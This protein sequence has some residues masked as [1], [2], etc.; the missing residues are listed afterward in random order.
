MGDG[1]IIQKCPSCGANVIWCVTVN[2]RKQPLN[3]PGE[4][5]I[6]LED[7]KDGEFLG[8]NRTAYVPHHATCPNLE[9]SHAGRG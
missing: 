3:Y 6:V 5:R 8:R 9:E 7:L 4:S 1:L 2:G